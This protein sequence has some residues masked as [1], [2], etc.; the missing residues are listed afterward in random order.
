MLLHIAK[1]YDNFHITVVAV[2]LR[3]SVNLCFRPN[4]DELNIVYT[5]TGYVSMDSR[6]CT[7]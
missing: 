5:A 2:Y 1:K 4:V 3:Y 7:L 6:Y